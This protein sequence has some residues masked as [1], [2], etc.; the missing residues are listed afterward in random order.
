MDFRLDFRTGNIHRCIHTFIR[1][2]FICILSIL[3]IFSKY[4]YFSIITVIRYNVHAEN[5]CVTKVS[6]L[7][8]VIII[9]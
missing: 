9:I 5:S 8:G 4:Y 1:M 7:K 3:I 6:R 2:H